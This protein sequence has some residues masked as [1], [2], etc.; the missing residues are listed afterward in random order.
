MKF[1]VA[2]DMDNKMEVKGREKQEFDVDLTS[3]T[4]LKKKEKKAKKEEAPII[5][6]LK[7][8]PFF[9]LVIISCVQ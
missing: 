4:K 1:C 3:A 8:V 6:G 7:P 9:K 2:I 5:P